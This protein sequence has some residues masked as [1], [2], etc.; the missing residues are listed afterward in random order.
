MRF[1]R[2]FFAA[3]LSW[4]ITLVLFTCAYKLISSSHDSRSQDILSCENISFTRTKRE[5][6]KPKEEEKLPPRVL[7]PEIPDVPSVNYQTEYKSYGVAALDVA[8]L[9]YNAPEAKVQLTMTPGIGGPP[10]DCAP[11][12]FVRVRPVYPAAA[13]Q[14]RIQGWVLLEFSISEIGSV[15]NPRVKR[16]FP[17]M[18]F[19]RAALNAIKKWRYKPKIENGKP[20]TL[21][22]ILIIIKFY[23]ETM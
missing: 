22:G 13:E 9:S 21:Q 12:P 14:N 4:F 1:T 10:A 2:Y 7:S 23:L 5:E 17:P 19:E 16:A 6:K 18:I 11:I 15:I 20:V 8:S 3:V